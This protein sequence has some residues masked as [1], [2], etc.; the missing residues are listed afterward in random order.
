MRAC[1]RCVSV[2]WAPHGWHGSGAGRQPRRH[3]DC[4]VGHFA[5]HGDGCTD[6]HRNWRRVSHVHRPGTQF[7]EKRQCASRRPKQPSKG[8]GV[9]ATGGRKR[10]AEGGTSGATEELLELGLQQRFL[11][12]DTI[13]PP[14]VAALRPFDETCEV[15]GRV[16]VHSGRENKVP[17]QLPISC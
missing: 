15:R 1:G 17:Q 2:T 11:C 3:M 7:D 5:A 12:C 13:S 9:M 14:S 4:R 10:V 6:V 8:L 16:E